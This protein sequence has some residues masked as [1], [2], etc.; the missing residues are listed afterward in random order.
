MTAPKTNPTN[1]SSALLDADMAREM[2]PLRVENGIWRQM[3]QLAA[4]LSAATGEQVS[5]NSLIR[6]TMIRAYGLIVPGPT[7]PWRERSDLLQAAREG[8]AKLGI[9]DRFGNDPTAQAVASR[10][11]LHLEKTGKS[12]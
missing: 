7:D 4:E 3:V 12:S 8:R 5:V 6:D 11:R 10:R 9:I 1:S 2:H